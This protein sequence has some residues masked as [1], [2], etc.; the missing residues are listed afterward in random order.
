ANVP[1][2]RAVVRP[3]EDPPT[4]QKA[5]DLRQRLVALKARFD[6]GQWTDATK[7]GRALV[8]E[9]RAIGYKPLIA[10]AL[11]QEGAMLFRTND[12]AAAER[13]LTDAFW[14]ADASRH[15]EIRAETAALLVHIVGYLQS[16]YQEAQG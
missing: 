2:L 9:P 7:N 10:E 6:A 4:R 8:R 14:T 16:R 3:P 11:A 1:L 15:D 12:P 13:A 5:N